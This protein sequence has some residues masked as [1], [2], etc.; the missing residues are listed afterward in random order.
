MYFNLGVRVLVV[1]FKKHIR[2]SALHKPDKP[3]ICWPI[4]SPFIEFVLPKHIY[5]YIYIHI[6]RCQVVVKFYRDLY[7]LY[8]PAHVPGSHARGNWTDIDFKILLW[9]HNSSGY[10][11]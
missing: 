11:N 1:A 8:R 6:A 9:K 10:Q 4:K 3:H 2:G 7:F 5:T